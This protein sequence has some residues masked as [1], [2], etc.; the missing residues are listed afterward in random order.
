M[1]WQYLRI[2]EIMI[3]KIP[4][5]LPSIL[6][7]VMLSGCSKEEVPL[8]DNS[9]ATTFKVELPTLTFEI[10]SA[11]MGYDKVNDSVNLIFSSLLLNICTWGCGG[12]TIPITMEMHFEKKGTNMEGVYEFKRYSMA[13]G[14]EFKKTS[15][16]YFSLKVISGTA[17][18]ESFIVK[19]DGSKFVKGTMQLNTWKDNDTTVVVPAKVNF[20][21][22]AI[23]P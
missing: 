12:G 17:S 14:P 23:G 5:F 19:S 15:L 9:L 11:G 3:M 13:T 2:I 10:P 8:S 16:P 18:I 21:T 4:F 22:Q 7:I 1:R 20:N 6:S